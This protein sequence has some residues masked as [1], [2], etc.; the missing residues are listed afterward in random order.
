MTCEGDRIPDLG[1]RLVHPGIW[2]VR[3]HLP[4]DECFDATLFQ[5]R[6]LLVVAQ[7]GVGLVFHYGFFPFYADLVA[8]TRRIGPDLTGLVHFCNDRRGSLY[9]PTDGAKDDFLIRSAEL[10]AC[11]FESNVHSFLED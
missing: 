4:A 10:D 8:S 2:R 5:E 6:Y 7:L 11:L 3:Q 1:S 9:S